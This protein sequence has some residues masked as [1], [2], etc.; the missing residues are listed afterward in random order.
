MQSTQMNLSTFIDETVMLD[1]VSLEQ[2]RIRKPSRHGKKMMTG[3]YRSRQND[4]AR[5]YRKT[6]RGKNQNIKAEPR[7]FS[8]YYLEGWTD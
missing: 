6:L 2:L 4:H 8:R 7:D 5:F 3:V 1:E